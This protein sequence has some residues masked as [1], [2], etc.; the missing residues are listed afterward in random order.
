MKVIYR[1]WS[2][3]RVIDPDDSTRVFEG[4]TRK[5]CDGLAVEFFAEK[6]INEKGDDPSDL[7]LYRI[8]APAVA[9]QKTALDLK[10]KTPA[11]FALETEAPCTG[12]AAA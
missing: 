1:I 2:R 4:A 7:I 6:F 9:E 3:R 11:E 8:D 5:E 12:S 10:I